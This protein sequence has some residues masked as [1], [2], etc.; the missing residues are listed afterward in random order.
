M[1]V[2]SGWNVAWVCGGEGVGLKA[3]VDVCEVGC[4]SVFGVWDG[5]GDVS[6]CWVGVGMG[7]WGCG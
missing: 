6:V 3:L 4:V 5:S 1:F 2:V 7:D